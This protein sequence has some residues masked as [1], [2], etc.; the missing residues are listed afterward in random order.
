V[1]KAGAAS[2]ILLSM[3]L[4]FWQAQRVNPLTLCQGLAIISLKELLNLGG[5]HARDKLPE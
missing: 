3:G 2:G 5:F 4:L 1:S